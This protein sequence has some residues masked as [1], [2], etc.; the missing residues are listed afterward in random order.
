MASKCIKQEGT[1]Q[2]NSYVSW[3]ILGEGFLLLQEETQKYISRTDK[4]H[5][6]IFCNYLYSLS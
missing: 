5:P 4:N 3:K 2:Q 6:K 1:S